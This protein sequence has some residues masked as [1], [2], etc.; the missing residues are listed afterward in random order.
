QVVISDASI[1]DTLIFDRENGRYEAKRKFLTI[2]PLKTYFLTIV[3]ANG[4][5]LKASCTIPQKP[6][7]PEVKSHIEG[8]DLLFTVSLSKSS[9]IRYF[10]LI[11]F[12]EGKFD[13]TG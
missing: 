1:G 10:T 5:S 2:K 12:A 13:Y 3:T 6:Q 8:E 7:E 11:P 9:D 4:K